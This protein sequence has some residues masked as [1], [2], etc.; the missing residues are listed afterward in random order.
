MLIHILMISILLTYELTGSNKVNLPNWKCVLRTCIDCPKYKIPTVESNENYDSPIIKFHI[1]ETFNICSK[2]GTI[3]S[4]NVCDLCSKTVHV[5]KK[6]VKISRRKILT[7]KELSIGS[8]MKLHYLP[9]L[10][11]FIYHIFYVQVLSKN[12]CGK[13]RSERC[14]SI[15]GDILSVRDYAE[16]LSAH[17]NLEIQ[18]DHFGNG[19]SLSIEG[20]NLQYIDED[21]EEHSEFHSH[22]SD[23]SRQDASTTHAH[24]TSML[25]ELKKG[26]KLKPKCTIWESTDGC[27]KQ[28]R[29]GASLYFLSVLSSNFNI[30]IDRMIGAPGHGKDIV[31][32]INACDKRYLKEKMCMIGTPEA[33]DSKKRMDAHAMIG[34][35]KSSWA[36]TCKLLLEDKL[37][38]K[39]VKSYRKSKKREA[40][41]IMDKRVYHLQ[42]AKDVQMVGMK[43]R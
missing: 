18:S 35:K 43:K 20:N 29:C 6:P 8:F 14:L 32:A 11:K 7:L 37:R 21:H 1:Y 27:C 28:Y 3:K 2:H 10:E 4:G 23:D 22:L 34:N 12:I 42:D 19:R 30:N 5:G 40:K 17:F 39:G 25:N 16:R 31:D 26:N 9:A 13:M 41:Q 24:M 15:P 33:D 38:E 36:V